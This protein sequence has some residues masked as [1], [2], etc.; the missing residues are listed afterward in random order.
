MTY[1]KIETLSR[2]HNTLLLIN[3][4]GEDTVLMADC[5]IALRDFVLKEKESLD[6]NNKEEV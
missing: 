1:E 4:R 5:L 2:I 6:K 3:T